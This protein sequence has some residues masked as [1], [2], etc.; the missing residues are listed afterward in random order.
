M[1]GYDQMPRAAK[2]ALPVVLSSTAAGHPDVDGLAE[3]VRAA[4]RSQRTVTRAIGLISAWA[5]ALP[6]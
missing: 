3:Q 2:N 1:G 6:R 5:C 4:V